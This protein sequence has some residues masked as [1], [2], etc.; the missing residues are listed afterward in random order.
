MCIKKDRATLFVGERKE[1]RENDQLVDYTL[2]TF[3]HGNF[4]CY[5]N[6]SLGLLTNVNQCFFG[7]K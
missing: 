1:E 5:Y 3:I 4:I 6:I 7:T 2:I